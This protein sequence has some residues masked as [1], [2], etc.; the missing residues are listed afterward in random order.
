[1]L[2][3]LLLVAGFLGVRPG[4]AAAPRRHALLVACREYPFLRRAL[5]DEVYGR[6]V[7]LRGP[8]NDAALWR[9]CSSVSGP[10]P[11]T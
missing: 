4:A 6:R 8:A 1:M 5:G 2:A 3:A 11:R 10:I 9:T 7:R